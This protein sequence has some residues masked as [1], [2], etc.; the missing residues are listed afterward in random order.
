[1]AR[2]WIP[3][4][5]IPLDEKTK[6]YWKRRP[7]GVTE[8]KRTYV[9]LAEEVTNDP[10]FPNSLYNEWGISEIQ[11]CAEGFISSSA[12]EDNIHSI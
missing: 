3:R 11:N 2:G 9:R 12:L 5:D 6:I 8:Y 10:E 4:M 1:M 7:K